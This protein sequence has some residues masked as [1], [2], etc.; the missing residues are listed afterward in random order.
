M[1]ISNAPSTLANKIS[2]MGPIVIT[3]SSTT[4][5]K[6]EPDVSVKKLQ[7]IFE[8]LNAVYQGMTF[9]ELGV[10]A[11]TEMAYRPT[12]TK[13]YNV[14][15]R[16]VYLPD[17]GVEPQ[18]FSHDEKS[19]AFLALVKKKTRKESSIHLALNAISLPS[20]GPSRGL[21]EISKESL[22]DLADKAH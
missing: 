15:K 3:M 13:L 4:E 2:V 16:L 20:S 12:T 19:P 17:L 8:K 18:G 21:P 9:K 22:G 5:A 14:V 7:E 6:V 1:Y 10:I 11:S